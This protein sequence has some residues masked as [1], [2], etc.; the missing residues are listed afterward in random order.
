MNETEKKLKR[1]EDLLKEN[2]APILRFFSPGLSK[3]FIIE[4]FN[5]HSISLRPELMALYEWHNG[6]DFDAAKVLQPMI[7]IMPMGI[8]YTL[9]FMFSTRSD[10]TRWNYIEN[11]NEYLPLFGSGEDDLY[12]LKNATG[13]IFYLAPASLIRGELWFKS[14]NAMLDCLIECYQEGILKIAPD[15]GLVV[16]FDEYEKKRVKYK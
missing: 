12:L 2:D 6:I 5:K 9:D 15:E 11:S 4:Y 14:I 1:L 3:E 7:E 13:E 8:F 10:L 16:M